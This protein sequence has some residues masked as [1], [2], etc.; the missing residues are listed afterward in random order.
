MPH[1]KA[2]PL[3]KRIYVDSEIQFGLIRRTLIHWGLYMVAV[4]MI[5]MIW[6][7]YRNH[8]ATL[9][10][11]LR[12]SF[13]N[14]APALFAGVVLLPLFLYDQLK[15]SHRM[16]GP[17]HRMRREMQKLSRG[18]GVQRLRFREQ[19]HWP[20]LAE[21]FNRLAETVIRNRRSLRN[22]EDRPETIMQKLSVEDEPIKFDRHEVNFRRR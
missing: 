1:S 20:Q 19:D 8:D 11:L 7:T 9:G 17:I 12:E 14:F 16:V 21:E 18:E 2:A 4:Q 10:N 3:R 5:V 6:F 13:I 15:F 22:T